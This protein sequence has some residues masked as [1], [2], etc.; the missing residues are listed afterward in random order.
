MERD[1]IWPAS[2]SLV[3]YW[4]VILLDQR[5]CKAERRST[6]SHELAHLDAG[7]RECSGILGD[8]AEMAADR[9]AARRLISIPQLADVARWT[10]YRAEA[11]EA[12]DVTTHLLAL[13]LQH[14]HPAER[15]YL[16][17]LARRVDRAA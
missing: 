16:N 3:R 1:D 9:L 15:G 4:D 17:A 14:L 2:G 8:R 7:D 5:L 10:N 11:A 12:M 6:L 13:R